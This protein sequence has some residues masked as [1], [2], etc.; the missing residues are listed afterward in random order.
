MKTQVTYCACPADRGRS[1]WMSTRKTL[2][3]M[4][5][6]GSIIITEETHF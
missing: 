5:V 1:A 6:R 2:Y 4:P 3:L